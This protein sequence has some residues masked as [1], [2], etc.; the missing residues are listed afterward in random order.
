MVVGICIVGEIFQCFFQFNGINFI[1]PLIGKDH[2]R[3]VAERVISL[4]A[5]WI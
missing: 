2:V 5:I 1:D 3:Y 4:F